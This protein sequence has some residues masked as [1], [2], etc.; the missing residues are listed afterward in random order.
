MTHPRLLVDQWGGWPV[1]WLLGV[2]H[3]EKGG[4][5]HIHAPIETLVIML[6]CVDPAIQI[7]IQ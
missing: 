1:N 6:S 2:I 7:K 4:K 5:L 3:S